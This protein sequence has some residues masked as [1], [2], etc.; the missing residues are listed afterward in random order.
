MMQLSDIKDERGIIRYIEGCIND[1]DAGIATKDETVDH[2]INLIIFL[3]KKKER[4]LLNEVEKV[5]KQTP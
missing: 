3:V 4:I 2:V 5:I 1:L